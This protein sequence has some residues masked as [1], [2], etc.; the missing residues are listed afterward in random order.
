MYLGSEAEEAFGLHHLLHDIALGA[1]C[2][3]V[4]VDNPVLE[5]DIVHCQTHVLLLAIDNGHGVELVDDLWN[6]TL[7]ELIHVFPP[8]QIISSL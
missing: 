6:T 5:V 3:V 2:A 4:F 8:H 1:C 7:V